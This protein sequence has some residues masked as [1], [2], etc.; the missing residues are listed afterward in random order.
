MKIEKTI[1]VEQ[2]REDIA[3]VMLEALKLK[4]ESLYHHSIQTARVLVY[5]GHSLGLTGAEIKLLKIAGLMHDTGKISVRTEIL[6]K[7]SEL[8]SAEWEQM[9]THPLAGAEALCKI[10][11][12]ARVVSIIE[13]HHEFNGNGYPHALAEHMIC[14][15]TKLLRAAD[16]YSAMT[17]QRAYKPSLPTKSV[18]AEVEKKSAAMEDGALSGL[19]SALFNFSRE[20]K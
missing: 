11:G 1:T 19:M 17:M 12:L 9:K 3:N 7:P 2:W 5:I 15:E 13:S 10:T 8:N 18:L 16:I 14:F 4:C 6:K 20:G